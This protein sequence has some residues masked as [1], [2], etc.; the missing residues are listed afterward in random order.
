MECKSP[1][2][3]W[4]IETLLIHRFRWVV[5]QLDTLRTCLKRSALLKALKGLPKT[6]DETYERILLQI[7]EEYRHDA[8]IVF[9]L[10][11][12]SPR[13]ISLGEAAEFEGR[14]DLDGADQSG[15]EERRYCQAQT[16]PVRLTVLKN[17]VDPGEQKRK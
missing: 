4:Y 9:T 17:T 7:S 11:A 3:Y 1:F 14:P 16:I 13:P 2:A 6:L 10:L 15:D 8:Q 12:F 5:C